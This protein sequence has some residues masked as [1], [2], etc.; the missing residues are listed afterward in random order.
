MKF[1]V[2]FSAFYF[3]NLI[4]SNQCQ[5]ESPRSEYFSSTL[6]N[7]QKYSKYFKTDSKFISAKFTFCQI[8]L[9]DI[10]VFKAHQP[11]QLYRLLACYCC[12]QLDYAT[13]YYSAPS[14]WK[15]LNLSTNF[16]KKFQI[17]SY[18]KASWMVILW[19]SFMTALIAD[20]R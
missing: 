16:K 13:W 11:N 8:L 2:A 12:S 6:E 9:F 14:G 19:N 1:S 4:C 10:F 15:T 17:F 5:P 18:C 7:F 20:S 3:V